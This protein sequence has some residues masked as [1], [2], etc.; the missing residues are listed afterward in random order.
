MKIG[1][2]I[3]KIRAEKDVSQKELAKRTKI[4]ATSLSQIEKG[5]KRPSAKNLTKI[6]KALDIP[7]SLVYFYGL[8]ANDIPAKNRKLYSVVFPA[9]E[10]MIK[11]LLVVS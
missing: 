2:A 11:K 7:E 5:T 10:D 6:C 8:E 9:L 4:S 1:L 3:K